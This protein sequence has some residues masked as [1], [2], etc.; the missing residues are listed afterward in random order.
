MP[1]EKSSTT[2]GV[3]MLVYVQEWKENEQ[4]KRSEQRSGETK[5]ERSIY[6]A[7]VNQCAPSSII[8]QSKS[9]THIL[10]SPPAVSFDG[11]FRGGEKGWLATQW[12]CCV[13]GQPV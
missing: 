11:E 1:Y 2:D 8:R 3:R 5:H 9:P 10:A 4:K 12:R 13:S 6:G 7:P